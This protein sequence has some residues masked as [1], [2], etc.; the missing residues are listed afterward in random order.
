MTQWKRLIDGIDPIPRQN[1]NTYA[2]LLKI[3]QEYYSKK[4]HTNVNI[5]KYI[6]FTIIQIYAWYQ[7]V[8]S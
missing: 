6:L 1:G 4:L 3:Q 2:D 5:F 8:I 7:L